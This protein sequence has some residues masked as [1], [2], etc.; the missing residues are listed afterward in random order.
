MIRLE[1]RPNP[2]RLWTAL[3][4]VVAVVLTMIAGGILFAALGKDPFEALRTI[5]WDP[6]FSEQFAAFSRPQLLIKAGPLILI[7][8]G[9]SLGFRAGIWNIGAE[10]QYIMGALCGAGL[11]L[12]FYPTQSALIFPAMVVAGALGGW[13]WAMIP[14]V[15][16]IRFGTNE[17]LVSLMLVYVAEALLA[18]AALGILRSPEGGGFPGSRNLS[19]ID[20]MANPEL[21]AGTGMHWGV[22][23]GFAAVIAAYV[24]LNRHILGYQIKLTG[25]APRAARFAGV[26]PSMLVAL[27]LGVSGA[28]AGLAGLFEV[29]GPAG[30]I[31]IDFN[32]GYGFTAIIVAFLGRLHPVGI[33]LAGLLMALTYI[34]G[35]LAQFMLG[36]PAAAIQAFQGM[37]L[38]FLLGVDVLSNYRIRIGKGAPA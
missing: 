38:F 4:P 12:A 35:E 33:L 26:N 6:L 28:L 37:L 23:T 1:K 16:K 36:I 5:F 32:S 15:L 10:G 30:Q 21:I 22:V 24:L 17:I 2:S 29:T 14:A 31:S 3:T 9:L 19:Q 7:A 13:A 18:S 8:I 34:G 20:A 27:C 25:Q 11:G